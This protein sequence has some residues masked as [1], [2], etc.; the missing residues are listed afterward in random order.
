[1]Q[2]NLTLDG[3]SVLVTYKRMKNMYLRVEP[4]DGRVCVSAPISTGEAHI[5]AFIRERRDWIDKRRAVCVLPERRYECGEQIPLWGE[6]RA[7]TLQAGRSGVRRTAEGLLLS[8]P[9][10]ADAE[11]RKHILDA[12]YRKELQKA[13]PP[14]LADCQRAAGAEAREW[15]IRDMKTRWGSC[16]VVERRIWLNLRLAEKPP[17]CL[18]Y[19]ILH[20]LCHLFERGHGKAFWARMDACCPDWRALRKRLNDGGAPCI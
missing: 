17:E 9:A 6:M 16:N 11:A 10:D 19:V 5:K 20:E 15:R 13:V 2:K 12:F 4:P 1:M 14:L 18:R 7:L 8:A 3:L